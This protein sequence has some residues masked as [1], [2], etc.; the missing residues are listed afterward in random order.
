MFPCTALAFAIQPQPLCQFAFPRHEYLQ[1]HKKGDEITGFLEDNQHLEAHEKFPQE[2]QEIPTLFWL[3]KFL[4][5]LESSK[6]F[7]RP[8][9]SGKAINEQ[10]LLAPVPICCK[11]LLVVVLW[12]PHT[13]P[14][15]KAEG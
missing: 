11:E 7:V 6:S 3:S 13:Y 12:L 10:H 14:T 8:Y 9:I 15:S 1:Y 5:V 4:H 2:F